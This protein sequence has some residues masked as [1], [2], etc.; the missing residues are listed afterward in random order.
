MTASHRLFVGTIGEGLFRSDDGGDTFRRRC[1]GMFVEC[2]VRALTVDPHDP[3]TLYLGNEHGVFVS[4]DAADSWRQLPLPAEGMQVWSLCLDARRP[5]RVLAGTCPARVFRSEDSGATWA[6]AQM[7][8]Q[9]GCPG[10]R[11]TRLTCF[12]AD[13]ADPDALWTGVE[14]DGVFHSDDGGQTWRAVGRGLSSQDIHALALVPGSP[15]RLLA[16]T[17]NDLN[18]STDEGETWQPMKIGEKMPWSYCRALAQK[19]TAPEVVFLGNGDAPPGE[20]GVVG[21][22]LDG[23]KT[24]RAAEMP[25]PGG[26]TNSTVW[27]FATHPADPEMVYAASVSGQVFRSPDGGGSWEKVRREFGE[28]RS[29]AW[30]PAG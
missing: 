17:N 18:L 23:G 14:I 28:V 13:P 9:Q 30:A 4:H 21:R 29:L 11:H 24:W 20:V 3:A 6:E 12:L 27:S 1:A 22:S 19:V 8:A 26:R 7:R 16:A 5:G 2:D 25:T 15:R 10:I